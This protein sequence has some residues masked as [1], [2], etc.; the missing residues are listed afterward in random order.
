VPGE[1]E[2]VKKDKF[3][4]ALAAYGQAMKSFHKG[5]FQKASELLKNFLEKEEMERELADRAEMYLMICQTRLKE[6]TFTLKTFE[7]YYN[8]GVYKINQGEYEEA[9]NLLNKAADKEPKEGKVPYLLATI[10]SRM[11]KPE[12]SLEYLKKAIQMDNYFSILAQN[13]VDFESFKEDKK[14]K[15]MTR[16]A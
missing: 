12:E 8:Y 7:D 16:M 1:K 3:Q 5:D 2:K 10:Y 11:E 14:F 13:E 6:E 15:L 9:V 4:K